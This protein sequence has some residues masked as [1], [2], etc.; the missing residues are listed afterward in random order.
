MM[1]EHSFCMKN[2]ADEI[3]QAIETALAAGLRTA[4]IAQQGD[5]VVSTTDITTA[6]VEAL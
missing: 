6:I 4:D 3:Y 5:R 1:F 2:V